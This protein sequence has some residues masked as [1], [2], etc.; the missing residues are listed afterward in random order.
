MELKRVIALD[1]RTAN[2]KAIQLYG[3]NVLVISSERVDNHT[4]LIVAVDLPGLHEAASEAPS[5]MQGI[6][7]NEIGAGEV[8]SA[9][10]FKKASFADA[11]EASAR[12]DDGLEGD[13][14]A[15]SALAMTGGVPPAVAT[16][17]GTAAAL[18]LT[19]DV[20]SPVAVME[21]AATA[22][23]TAEGVPSAVATAEQTA[24]EHMHDALHSREIV[25]WLR[26]EF[27]SLRRELL[28]ARWQVDEAG[29]QG[30]G[31]PLRSLAQALA[32]LGLPSGLR[33][34]L[35][36]ELQRLQSFDAPVDIASAVDAL[37]SR[38]MSALKKTATKAARGA[39]GAARQDIAIGSQTGLQVLVGP[40]GAGKTTLVARLATLGAAAQG[41]ASQA[42]VSYRDARPGAWSQL[43]TLAAQAGIDC[44]RAPDEATFQVILAE[45]SD[46]KTVWVDTPGLNFMDIA[47]GVKA[48]NPK[49]NV[50]AV[51]PVDATLT[52]AARVVV[53]AHGLWS[54]LMLTKMDEAAHPWPLIAALTEFP[55]PVSLVSEGS[56]QSLR[57]FEARDLVTC[58]LAPF[59]TLVAPAQTGQTL[60][61]RDE[62][63]TAKIDGRSTTKPARTTKK[64]SCA[65]TRTSARAPAKAAASTPVVARMTSRSSKRMATHA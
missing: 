47:Q 15:P 33:D 5:T 28:S 14:R 51:L 50:H 24:A 35:M 11:L 13:R 25:A 54:S 29:V 39:A 44:Y 36:A 22:A 7:M 6:E 62:A 30:W 20:P 2:E 1:M 27:D 42:V 17:E 58:A 59:H 43:Q 32:S 55:T 40:S 9:A 53:Q 61:V 18:A 52:S 31:E 3:E 4:E 37:D 64:A 10:E 41:A 12:G 21:G 57:A 38:L 63:P 46:R 8:M 56:A 49:V 16:M 60:Q 23:A 34:M 48:Q 65:P 26:E 45:L 19:G